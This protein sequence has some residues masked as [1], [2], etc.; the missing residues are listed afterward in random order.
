MSHRFVL[1]VLGLAMVAA[2][3]V[4][5]NTPSAAPDYQIP[6]QLTPGTSV[7]PAGSDADRRILPLF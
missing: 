5:F 3:C 7:V 4:S 2:G 6:H 1:T